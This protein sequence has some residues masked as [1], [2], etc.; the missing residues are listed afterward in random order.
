MYSGMHWLPLRYP[1]N[2]L[3]KGRKVNHSL[4]CYWRMVGDT[5]TAVYSGKRAKAEK[6]R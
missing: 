5:G 1:L 4:K 3:L 6:E 2:R